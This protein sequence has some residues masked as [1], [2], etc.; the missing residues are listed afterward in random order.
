MNESE[1]RIIQSCYIWHHNSF[2]EKRGLFFKIK[3]EGTNAITG[4]RDKSTGL[5]PGVADSCL[6][7]EGKAYFIEFKTEIGK[8]SDKQKNWQAQIEADGHKYFIC[9]SLDEFKLIVTLVYGKILRIN[10]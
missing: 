8:Q 10:R 9:R 4:M 1:A 5:I 6:L 7:H 2:P 3:N